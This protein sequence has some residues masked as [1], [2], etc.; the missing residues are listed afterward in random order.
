MLDGLTRIYIKIMVRAP[1][2]AGTTEVKPFTRKLTD[3]F[4]F[5]KWR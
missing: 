3:G 4:N 5:A 2:A 1:E